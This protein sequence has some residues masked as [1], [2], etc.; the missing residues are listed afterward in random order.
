[1][2]DEDSGEQVLALICIVM[3]Y[4]KYESWDSLS[5]RMKPLLSI[6]LTHVSLNL[7]N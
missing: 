1:M 6:S 2:D 5:G 4:I 3:A 7:T